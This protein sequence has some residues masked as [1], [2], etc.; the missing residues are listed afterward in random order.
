M[1]VAMDLDS[2]VEQD[3][4]GEQLVQGQERENTRDFEIYFEEEGEDAPL[5]T[6]VDE[7]D[8]DVYNFDVSI[9]VTETENDAEFTDALCEIEGKKS[10]PCAKCNKVCKSKGGLTRHTNSKHSEAVPAGAVETNA[11]PLCEDTVASIVESVKTKH[12][13]ED[14]YGTE[15]NAGLTNVSSS[16]NLFQALLLLYNTFSRKKNQDKLLQS[17]YGLIPCSCEL[18]N[19]QD[20]RT[21]NLVMIEIPDHLVGFYNVSRQTRAQ[22]THESTSKPELSPAERGPLSYVA[23][24]VVSKLY[25]ASRKKKETGKC[26]EELKALL[27]NM[28]STEA[29]KFHIRSHKRWLCHSL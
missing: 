17:F 18:L 13:E 9:A 20:Y 29:P 10:L 8:F 28:K 5:D 25:Q 1:H 4:G 3:F 21:A 22:T 14:L 7:A 23:G 11:T 12:I 16:E 15:T 27:L 6:S 19:C 26:N 24:Y 2:D